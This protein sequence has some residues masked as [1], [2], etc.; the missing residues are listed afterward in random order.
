KERPLAVTCY[1]H[2]TLHQTLNTK[3]SPAISSK[4]TTMP[5]ANRKFSLASGLRLDLGCHNRTRYSPYP[6]TTISSSSSTA[7]QEP[8]LVKN[9]AELEKL[10]LIGQ[11]NGGTVFKVRHAPTNKIYALKKTTTTTTSHQELSIHRLISSLSSSHV[12]S[13]L[14]SFQNDVVG[15]VS[16]LMEYMNG[17][18]LADFA[19]EKE[20][21]RL[22]EIKISDVARQVLEGVN[23]LHSN[24]VVHRDIKPANFLVN[25]DSTAKIVEV[26]IADF[27]VSKKL[28]SRLSR[29]DDYVGT[30]AYLSPER[31][32]MSSNGGGYDGFAADVWSLGLVFLELYVGR[33]PLLEEGKKPDWPALMC[34]VCF[35]EMPPKLPEEA[36]EEFKDFVKC[37]LQKDPSKRWSVAQLMKHPFVAVKK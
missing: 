10:Q 5:I 1:T 24:N 36:S 19:K 15:N 37:C 11:G 21:G 12:V 26:K 9:A 4:E 18:S 27:G 17:G 30:T 3:T 14:G 6:S 25:E 16:I 22:S 32:D 13:F 29:C 7:V 33:Y 8:T 34:A 28:P 23:V 20:G 2:Y 31:F 35:G